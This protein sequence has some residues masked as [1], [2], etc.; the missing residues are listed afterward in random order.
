MASR[1]NLLLADA[2]LPFVERKV[3]MTTADGQ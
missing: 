2:P 3:L 1:L